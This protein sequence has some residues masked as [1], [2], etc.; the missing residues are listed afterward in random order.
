M[1]LKRKDLPYIHTSLG[2]L[3]VGDRAIPRAAPKAV[4]SKKI[5]MMKD[6]MLGGAFVNAYSRPVMLAKISDIAMK[7][8]AGV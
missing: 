6:F 1:G 4:W 2:F 3:A 7:K 8:Y 5:D